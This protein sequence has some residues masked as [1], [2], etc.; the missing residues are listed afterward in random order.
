LKY[1]KILKGGDRDISSS[2]TRERE[3]RTD[4]TVD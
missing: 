2:E 4:D 3:V 1:N